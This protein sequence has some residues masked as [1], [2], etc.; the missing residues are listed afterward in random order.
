MTEFNNQKNLLWCGLRLG[1]LKL[2]VEL[3]KGDITKQKVD[4]I[5]NAANT[6]LVMG[7]GLAGAIRRAGGEGINDEAI[8]KGPIPLGE[9]TVTKAG[10]LKAKFVIHAASMHL[11]S[12]ATSESIANSV[13]NSLLRAEE[14]E[15]KTIAFP[16]VGCGIADFPISKGAKII[17][18]TIKEF[19]PTSLE[20]AIVILFLQSDYKIIENV[21]NRP[22][23]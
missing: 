7:G 5:V 10:R 16:A 15:L 3:R 1:E 20:K 18:Q 8:K 13:R 21:L 11:G 14:L 23:I 17:L 6:Q 22:F 19:E 4:A 12:V 2:K 9:A